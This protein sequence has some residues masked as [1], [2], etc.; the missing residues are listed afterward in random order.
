M[1]TSGVRQALPSVGRSIAIGHGQSGA[2]VRRMMFACPVVY[3]YSCYFVRCKPIAHI[4]ESYFSE[5]HEVDD[6]EAAADEKEYGANARLIVH[7]PELL[8]ALKGLV[9]PID[10]ANALEHILDCQK[11]DSC[12]LCIARRAIDEAS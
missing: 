3:R 7:A 12:P 8:S 9:E 6:E 10:G 5:E 11:A 1:K 2:H 4:Y